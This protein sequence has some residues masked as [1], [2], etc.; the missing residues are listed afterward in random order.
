MYY[1]DAKKNIIENDFTFNNY[2]KNAPLSDQDEIVLTFIVRIKGKRAYGEWDANDVIREILHQQYTNITLL[3]EFDIEDALENEDEITDDDKR[4]FVTALN[5]ITKAFH[6]LVTSNE[7]TARNYINP[8]MI[9]A[10]AIA[11]RKHPSARL[12]VKEDFDG[13]RGFGHL[14][15]AIFLVAF[16]VLV[17]EAKMTEVNK[18]ITQNLVQLHSAAENIRKRKRKE[19]HHPT[20]Y[21]VNVYGIV[22]T[23]LEWR[24]IHW[25]D[26][27]ESPKVVIS[28]PYRCTFNR[29][30]MEDAEKVLSIII[31][32]I[33][34]QAIVVESQI[35]SSKGIYEEA[36]KKDNVLRPS[37]RQR[38]DKDDEEIVEPEQSLFE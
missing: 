25:S 6:N 18:G 9:K 24:F 15:Y 5:E 28:K 11:Q 19:S 4:T 38:S 22:T 14:D 21:L 8:F 37:R 17:T 12:A 36:M 29:E 13:S 31:R 26:T 30:G 35:G 34:S 16:A 23:G 2:L 33:H 3:P 10:V 32:I 7:A 27:L 1:V 20:D